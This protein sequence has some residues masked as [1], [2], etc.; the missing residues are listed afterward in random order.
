MS[1]ALEGVRVIALETSA[2]MSLGTAYL[3]DFGAEVVKLEPL[4]NEHIGEPDT[5]AGPYQSE[6]NYWADFLDR[7]KESVTLDLTQDAGKELVRKLVDKSDVFATDLTNGALEAL[8]LSYGD[9][10]EVKPEIVYAVCS[11]FGHHGPDKDKPVVD[12]LAAARTGVMPIL[13]QPEQPP[14]YYGGG[15]VIAALC[16]AYGVVAALCH[17]NRT[18]EGQRVDASLFGANVYWAA[19]MF[20][21]YLGTYFLP[22]ESLVEG[23][24]SPLEPMRKNDGGQPLG[25]IYPTKDNWIFMGFPHTDLYWHDFCQTIEAEWLEHDPRFENHNKRCILENRRQLAE[26]LDQVFAKRS[27]GEWLERWE[28]KRYRIDSVQN[29]KD[30]VEDEQASDNSYIIDMNHP[31]HGKIRLLWNPVQCS[32]TPPMLSSLAPS[33]GQHNSEVLV[34]WLGY[35][36]DGIYLLRKQGVVGP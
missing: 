6:W 29:P 12:E 25:N 28:G 10:S 36:L 13:P 32:K 4:G 31:S 3:A 24:F 33:L 17:K 8:S 27:V 1:K 5:R 21:A 26:I 20:Q 14:V 30:I 18:G 22:P 9:V 23:I 16:M 35:T 19:Y 2:A 7:N 34:N 15:E 11:C